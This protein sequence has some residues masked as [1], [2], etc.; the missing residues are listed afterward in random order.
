[1][2]RLAVVAVVGTNKRVSTSKYAFV[3][4]SGNSTAPRALFHDMSAVKA[5][6]AWPYA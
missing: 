4:Y 5:Y 3:A 6:H 2:L 1:M